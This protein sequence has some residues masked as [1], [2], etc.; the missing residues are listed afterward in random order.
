[1]DKQKHFVF[2]AA[3]SN[4]VMFPF[5]LSVKTLANYTT[6]QTNG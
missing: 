6:L 3:S 2:L 4:K 1:M 5:S